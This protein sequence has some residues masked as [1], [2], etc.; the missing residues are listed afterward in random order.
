M[1]LFKNIIFVI[2]C[3]IYLYCLIMN[4]RKY[5]RYF[6]IEKQIAPYFM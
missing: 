6:T 4:T 5:K 2:I 1:P 3:N